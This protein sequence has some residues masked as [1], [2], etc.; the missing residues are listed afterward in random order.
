MNLLDLDKHG[1]NQYESQI[2]EVDCDKE[3]LPSR[4]CTESEEPNK[5]TPCSE[6]PKF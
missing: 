2:P 6:R 5:P 3:I 1:L 4:N